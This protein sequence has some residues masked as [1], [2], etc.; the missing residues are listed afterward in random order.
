L[1]TATAFFS[2]MSQMMTAFTSSLEIWKVW[3]E[4]VDAMYCILLSILHTF[5]KEND[6]EILPAHYTW[7]VVGKGLKIKWVMR[8]WERLAGW[9]I[10]ENQNN[11]FFCQK[12]IVKSGCTLYLYYTR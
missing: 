7:K 8:C 12:I 11:S 5:F 6:D 10:L 2:L 9:N 1:A 3:G 4:N